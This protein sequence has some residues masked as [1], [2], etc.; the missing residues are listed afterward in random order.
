MKFDKI[1]TYIESKS[2]TEAKNN[3]NQET[4]FEIPR[5]FINIKDCKQYLG[6]T[7]CK[8]LS[9]FKKNQISRDSISTTTITFFKF[10]FISHSV[11]YGP[12]LSYLLTVSNL[13]QNACC[14]PIPSYFSM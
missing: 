9:S 6:P 4:F 12:L 1:Y 3:Y 2:F 8:T 11:K 10:K 5:D 13:G 7:I 14:Q